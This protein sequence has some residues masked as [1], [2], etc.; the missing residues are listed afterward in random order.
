[1]AFEVKKY[2]EKAFAELQVEAV[3]TWGSEK[4][5][6]L[7]AMAL[8]NANIGES[9]YKESFIKSIENTV[10]S[11][12]AAIANCY[13]Y[14]LTKE[15]IY[16]NNMAA[17]MEILKQELD[18][19]EDEMAYVFYMKYETKVGG[20]EHYQDVVNRMIAA[21]KK[22]DKDVAYFMTVLVETLDSVDQ[23]I[24]EHYHTIKTM[25]KAALAQAL[26]LEEMDSTQMALMGYSIL[27]A[28]RMRAILSEKYEEIGMQLAD[29]ALESAD[30]ADMDMGACLMAYA[31]K[32]LHN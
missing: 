11:K 28:C 14:D 2:L 3:D 17:A 10:K 12:Y 9:C 4:S 7:T 19:V 32:I 18:S 8:L 29:A 22:E 25:F 31:E 5:N 27:K 23:M 20:K 1:M 24:Y 6:I 21:S 13:A 16:K 26:E 15:D 30:S